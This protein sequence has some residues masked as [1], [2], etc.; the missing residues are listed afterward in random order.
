MKIGGLLSNE[1]KNTSRLK[2]P[3]KIRKIQTKNAFSEFGK[4]E[5]K[6]YVNNC[7]FFRKEI[8]KET[9]SKKTLNNVLLPKLQ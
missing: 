5:S 8:L 9:S 4:F 1:I 6:K 7:K 2:Y 3:F